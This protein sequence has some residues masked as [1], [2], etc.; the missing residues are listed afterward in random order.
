MH[1]VRDSDLSNQVAAVTSLAWLTE[2]GPDFEPSVSLE[3]RLG[4]EM[5]RTVV[6]ELDTS[7]TIDVAAERRRLE[8][9]LAGAQKE[10]ASTAAKLANADFL[11]KAPDA[12][13][14]KIRDRQRVAQQ[15]T[16]RITTRLAA[17]Q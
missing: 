17:L 5:N 2:P 10:L 9:E 15:E 8:K 14:A 7:G 16:E 4:P 11:A 6:V 12:V 3:V 1:G 13:I